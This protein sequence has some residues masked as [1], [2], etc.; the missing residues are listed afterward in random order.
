MQACRRLPFTPEN[1][2]NNRGNTIIEPVEAH[3][4][5]EHINQHY[6]TTHGKWLAF[7]FGDVPDVMAFD[8]LQKAVKA[9]D[10]T[11]NQELR[12]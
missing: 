6:K 8:S 9:G 3:S 4:E 5:D 7:V 1:Q 12:I 11:K 10:R 2:D